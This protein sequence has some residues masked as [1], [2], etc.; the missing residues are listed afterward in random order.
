MY[1]TEVMYLQKQ[2]VLH[3]P[4]SMYLQ[5]QYTH[6]RLGRT[7]EGLPGLSPLVNGDIR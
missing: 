2:Y 1:T 3:V 5:K 7:R 6:N 4:T